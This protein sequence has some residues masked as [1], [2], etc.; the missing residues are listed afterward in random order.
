MD[1]VGE[2]VG[3]GT[4]AAEKSSFMR[5]AGRRRK[6][7]VMVLNRSAI[8]IRTF[9]ARVELDIETATIRCMQEQGLGARGIQ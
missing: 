6:L 8:P 2:R 9:G 4:T 5:R 3:D 1:R 7:R